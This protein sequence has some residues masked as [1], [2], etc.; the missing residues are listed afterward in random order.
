L[1]NQ[2]FFLF[3]V[4]KDEAEFADSLENELSEQRQRLDYQGS[5]GSASTR[6]GLSAIV[7]AIS[8]KSNINPSGAQVKFAPT[9]SKSSSDSDEQREMLQLRQILESNAPTISSSVSMVQTNKP[10]IKSTGASSSEG[11]TSFFSERPQRVVKRITRSL[12]PEGEEYITVQYIVSD[13][14]VVRVERENNKRQRDLLKMS[15][16]TST[17]APRGRPSM[18]TVLSRGARIP[19]KKRPAGDVVRKGGFEDDDAD[20]DTYEDPGAIVLKLRKTSKSVSPYF[21]FDFIS[22]CKILCGVIG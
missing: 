12:T 11:T 14:E 3:I 18:Q 4:L 19:A 13:S 10:E 1:P 17:V 21:Y 15:E 2:L 7:S 9:K 16:G 8:V 5:V 22:L 6:P 20:F